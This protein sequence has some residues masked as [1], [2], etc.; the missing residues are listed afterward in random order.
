MRK[1]HGSAAIYRSRSTKVHRMNVN[2]W[3]LT[4]DMIDIKVT[5]SF[6]LKWSC[7]VYRA[8]EMSLCIAMML[9]GPPLLLGSQGLWNR[10]NTRSV[11]GRRV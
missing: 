10:V 5:V 2:S 3:V 4:L 9:N 8:C 6:L 7:L 1:G 11:E